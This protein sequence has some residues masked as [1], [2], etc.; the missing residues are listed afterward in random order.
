MRLP[1]E[2]EMPVCGLAGVGTAPG[3]R[4]KGYARALIKDTLDIAFGHFREPVAALTTD[5]PDLYRKLGFEDCSLLVEW[6]APSAAAFA[7][8]IE[9]ADMRLLS[10]TE[11]E[12]MKQDLRGFH[13]RT[14]GLQP[15]QFLRGS[16]RWLAC[17]SFRPQQQ[18]AVWSARGILD[19]VIYYQET[20]GE[21]GG[22]VLSID[23]LG[24]AS[25]AGARAISGFLAR[26]PAASTVRG[27]SRW[28]DLRALGFDRRPGIELTQ[29]A[30]IMMR[31]TDLYNFLALLGTSVAWKSALRCVPGGLTIKV[32]DAKV[33]EG[34]K[35]VRVFPITLP[36]GSHGAGLS[37]ADEMLGDWVSGDIAAITQLLIG[38]RSAGDL[39]A[40]ERLRASSP[41]TLNIATALFPATDPYLSPLD[42]F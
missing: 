25:A 7:P 18:V 33:T 36:D 28:T 6:A 19:A 12:R 15:G 13:E 11:K 42:R 20:G 8:F 38:F 34:R 14:T 16:R 5:Q 27:K 31:L 32:E 40:E 17:E 41:S 39:H 23:G 24:A 26:R 37:P 3:Q 10:T 2:V 9:G 1:G 4:C 35:P 29:S 22:P 21:R 30:G